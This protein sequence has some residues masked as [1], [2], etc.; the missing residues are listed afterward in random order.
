M[1]KSKNSNGYNVF[2]KNT[3]MQ[4][5]MIVAQ[6]IFPMLTFP[7]LTRVLEPNSYGVIVYLTALISY[8]Q[9]IVDFG[10]NLSSTRKIAENQ[11]DIGIINNIF[12]STIYAKVFLIVISLIIYTL[13]IPFIDIL[14][15]NILLSYL[16]MGTVVLSIFLPDFLF[17]GI[18]KMGVI[19]YRF[20][21]SKTITTIFT[22]ILVHSKDDIIL[23]PV[24]NI[25][26][27]IVAIIWTWYEIKRLE[28]KLKI[29][30]IKNV[31]ETLRESSIYFISTFATTAFGA[32]NTFMLGAMSLPTTHIAY[33]GVS[34]NLI[35]SAQSLYSPIV[36]SLYPRMSA[37]KDFNL[38]KKIL[39]IFI[40]IITLIVVILYI[41]TGTIINIFSGT[42]YKEAIPIFRA[43]LPMLIFAFPGMV[44]GFPVLGV[45]GKV[46][47]TS[48]TTIISALFHVMG[49]LVMAALGIFT[50]LNVAI[51]RSLTEF[52]LLVSR[53]FILTKYKM[54]NKRKI[55]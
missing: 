19:T 32:T 3:I 23:I 44:L 22:F 35:S 7:Y 28:I 11:G 36:N 38:V 53:V 29:C 10:F 5:I 4:Y 6:Y 40:P 9:I 37:K 26:G 43:L 17:R 39:L 31:I 46:K 48:I 49:L 55:K 8:F 14:N 25:I 1:K 45:I 24:L 42:Q 41:I 47:E 52:L 20:L 34:Y 50:I 18:E 12:S 2:I 51:L 15:K 30:S 21:I 16:Y 33:W 27:S 54:E 13:L